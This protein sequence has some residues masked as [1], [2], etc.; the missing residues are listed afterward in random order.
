M[1]L[2]VIPARY[3]SSRFPGKPLVDI[4]GK[5]M[6]ERVYEQCKKSHLLD[7]VL[8][9]TDDERIFS[10]VVMFGGKVEMTSSTHQS[11]TERVC[12]IAK[13]Y[14]AYSHYVN[15]Q[16]DEP[17][18]DPAQIDLLCKTLTNS[19]LP[20]ATL[21][22]PLRHVSQLESRD[23]AKVVIDH[24]H[25]A[26]YF[27]RLPIPY[28]RNR[29]DTAQWVA[30]NMYYLHLGIYGFERKVLLEIPNMKP[31]MMEQAESLEQL[32]WLANGYKIRTAITQNNSI[33]V[34]TPQ[35]LRDLLENL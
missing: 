18:L 7:E 35:D 26:L 27:S 9:A 29:T 12:E 10:H 15:I 11:G 14:P 19:R 32:R 23:T 2:G 22:K 31:S 16:G 25:N 17:F 13:N 8:V 33:S 28:N 1:I 6:V 34:D 3:E 5:S 21:I 30:K 24:E 4:K 20:I